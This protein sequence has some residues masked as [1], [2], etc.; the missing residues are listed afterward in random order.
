MINLCFFY[1]QS[2]YEANILPGINLSLSFGT[3]LNSLENLCF[4]KKQLAQF[5]SYNTVTCNHVLLEDYSMIPKM[6]QNSHHFSI[7]VL[8]RN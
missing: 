1:D 7:Y 8:D 5:E 6:S 4:T 3:S 2:F